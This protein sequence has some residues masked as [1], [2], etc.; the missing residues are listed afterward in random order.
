MKKTNEKI[1]FY[2][3]IIV[4]VAIVAVSAFLFVS[5]RYTSYNRAISSELPDKCATPEGYTDQ[6][7]R[8]HMSHHPDRYAECLNTK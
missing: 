3:M 6:Q 7:W 5:N 2:A 1:L 4:A 8:D